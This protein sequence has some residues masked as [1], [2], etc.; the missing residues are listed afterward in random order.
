MAI[1]KTNFFAQSL[2]QFAPNR[3]RGELLDWGLSATVLEAQ[4]DASVEGTLYAGDPVKIASTSTGKLK[5][6]PAES[7]DPFC[8]YILFNPKHDEWKAGMICSILVTNGILNCVTEEAL[9]AG[10]PVYYKDADGS[11]TADGAAG[12]RV[13][14]ITMAKVPATSG[15]IFVPV[16][17]R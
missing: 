13:M 6:V 8:G 14:G 4:I 2:N 15:G 7:T 3:V 11:I 12:A 5:V 17:I 10:T 16:M 9:N 1:V